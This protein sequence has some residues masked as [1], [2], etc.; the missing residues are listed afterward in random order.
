MTLFDESSCSVL[1][2]SRPSKEHTTVLM[3]EK[4][5]PKLVRFSRTKSQSKL[6]DT[7]QQE[8]GVFEHDQA[9]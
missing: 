8:N 6:T 2:G 5:T 1:E 9:G 3:P 7:S 4:M